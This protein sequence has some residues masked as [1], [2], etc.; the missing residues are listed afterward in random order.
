MPITLKET[1]L[2]AL[3]EY[4]SWALQ[5]GDDVDYTNID[6]LE[7]ER[8]VQEEIDDG[9]DEM[10]VDIIDYLFG[11]LGCKHYGVKYISSD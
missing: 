7:L 10:I 11:E 8:D 5:A 1:I 3:N 4:K 6:M 9:A 2:D